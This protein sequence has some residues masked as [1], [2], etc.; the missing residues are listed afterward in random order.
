MFKSICL[1]LVL[2]ATIVAASVLSA[3]THAQDKKKEGAIENPQP[4]SYEQAEAVE[5][6]RR[7]LD[8]AL[9]ETV[10]AI[11][12]DTALVPA[13]GL[14]FIENQG[15]VRLGT[16]WQHL[17]ATGGTVHTP[18]YAETLFF[19]NKL[20]HVDLFRYEDQERVERLHRARSDQGQSIDSRM[21]NVEGMYLSGHGYTFTA[22]IP[23]HYRESVKVPL[24]SGQPMSSDWDRALK[25][26]RGEKSQSPQA[27]RKTEPLT[28]ADS[29]LKVLF[30]NGEHLAIG[31]PN[32]NVIVGRSQVYDSDQVSV[33]ITLRSTNCVSCHQQGKAAATGVGQNLAA[34]LAKSVSTTPSDK[35]GAGPVGAIPTDET[36]NLVL[37]GELRAKQNQFNE[38]AEIFQRA[39]TTLKTSYK[40]DKKSKSSDD[41]TREILMETSILSRTADCQKAAGDAE[42]LLRSI[43][44]IADNVKLLEQ[45]SEKIRTKMASAQ[46]A[47]WGKRQPG[48]KLPSKLLICVPTAHK[49]GASITSFEEFKR[50]ASVTYQTFE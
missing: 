50:T 13:T 30:E 10:D 41:D 5:I 24:K 25:E 23:Y 47:P 46:Q 45:I 49:A 8:R 38:A 36:G 27:N 39:L 14:N 20:D 7:L 9:R 35:S 42:S 44:M 43:Q 4:N 28:L 40:T 22:T 12:P 29:V 37:L 32:Q 6:M 26:L 48:V 19:L 17:A 31:Q 21:P 2:G 16:E 3:E 33:V 18:Y 34:T 1:L 11:S 15:F